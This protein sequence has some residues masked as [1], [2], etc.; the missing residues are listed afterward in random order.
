MHQVQGTRASASGVPS[1]L[2]GGRQCGAAV[3][4][5]GPRVVPEPGPSYE[6]AWASPVLEPTAAPNSGLLL[7]CGCPPPPPPVLSGSLTARLSLCACLPASGLALTPAGGC[8]PAVPMRTVRRRHGLAARE[9]GGLSDLVFRCEE[10]CL[11]HSPLSRPGGKACPPRAAGG[12]GAARRVTLRC[13]ESDFL[14]HPDCMTRSNAFAASV[15]P[16]HPRQDSDA[17]NPPV[18]R[19]VPSAPPAPGG[20]GRETSTV[21]SSEPSSQRRRQAFPG[22]PLPPG[23]LRVSRSCGSPT[24]GGARRRLCASGVAGTGALPSGQRCV[25]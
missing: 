3:Q 23:R 10:A 4:D 18:G 20:H 19:A 1:D 22:A 21:T 7:C 11:I 15:N 17:W 13:L 24:A 16:S 2:P 8:P 14:V 25:L 5:L 6:H 12:S 9:S